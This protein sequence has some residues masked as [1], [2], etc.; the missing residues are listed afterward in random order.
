[1][2]MRAGKC[3]GVVHVHVRLHVY[4]CH[5]CHTR[6][7][8]DCCISC[9]SMFRGLRTERPELLRKTSPK[10]GIDSVV[11][12]VAAEHGDAAGPC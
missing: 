7:A 9:V 12:S 1:M 6:E 11:S 8:R 4:L 2:T 5:F 3:D 10:P